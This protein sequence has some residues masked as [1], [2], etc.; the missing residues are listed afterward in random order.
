M[1]PTNVRVL[2]LGNISITSLEKDAFDSRRMM[3][4]RILFIRYCQVETIEVGA[5]NGLTELISLTLSHNEISEIIPRTFE[6]TSRLY[7][8]DLDDN[9]IEYLEV[10]VFRGLD[11]LE[12]LNLGNNIL[13]NLNPDLFVGLSK[14]QRLVLIN[15]PDLHIPTEHHFINSHSLSHLEISYCNVSSVSVETFA[16]VSALEMLDLSFNNLRSVNI[17]ILR[18]LPKLSALYLHSN[19][20][21][22]DCQLQEVW[23]WCQDHDIQ[24]AFEGIAPECDTPSEVEGIWWGV[25]EKG[26]CLKHN[27]Q[28]VQGGKDL[29]SGEC[30]LGQ[31]IPI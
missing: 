12:Y 20:L 25:L 4:L 7:Y 14:L 5:F 22:C 8:L 26:Q 17:N 23:R 31:T 16:N 27:I 10:D 11:N 15:N 6:K 3:Y 19:P 28:G 24:I 2:E 1:F 18:S 13:L 29:T 30:S 9:I 21:Q